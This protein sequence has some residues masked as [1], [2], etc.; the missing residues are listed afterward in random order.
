MDSKTG[1]TAVPRDWKFWCIIVSLAIGTLVTAIELTSVGTA[2]PVIVQ[3]LKGDKFVWVGSAYTLGQTALIPFCGGLAQIF[4]RRLVIL[5]GIALFCVGSAV[6]GAATSMNF[7]IGG[8]TVQ[9]L[10]AGAMIAL[11]QIIIADLVPLKERG[12][13]NGIMPL[14]EVK[15]IRLIARKQSTQLLQAV[16]PTARSS[17]PNCSKQSSQLQRQSG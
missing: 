11:T 8:R 1:T 15:A 2:L 12:S 4:G 6:C 16:Y 13:F 7:L 5:S 10:G 3:D 17:L 14:W 9:G